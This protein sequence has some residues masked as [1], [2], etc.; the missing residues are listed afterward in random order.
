[1]ASPTTSPRRRHPRTAADR[2][3][4]LPL[5][6]AIRP[7]V[8]RIPDGRRHLARRIHPAPC[9]NPARRAPGQL[10]AGPAAT[11]EA[12]VQGPARQM[13]DGE[14]PLLDAPVFGTGRATTASPS[15]RRQAGGGPP[16]RPG[17]R[18]RGRAL[19]QPHRRRA[20]RRPA[21]TGV[22]ARQSG[23]SAPP[24]ATAAWA[25]LVS[26]PP[27]DPLTLGEPVL[28]DPTDPFD[29]SAWRAALPP[30]GADPD[31]IP[32]LTEGESRWPAPTGS[33]TRRPRLHPPHPSRTRRNRG[34]GC[35]PH[36]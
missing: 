27:P 12:M 11:T 24:P 15:S 13:P 31:L 21:L 30:A 20:A 22:T 23:L 34:R 10:G 36:P 18:G 2:R 9:T 6:L 1:L 7:A 19:R 29:Y 8:V 5:L 33:S 25:E 32:I 14:G 28:A 35:R 4:R 17:R 26:A 3:L 16:R